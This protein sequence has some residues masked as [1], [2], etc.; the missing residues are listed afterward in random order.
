MRWHIVVRWDA[1]KSSENGMPR[2]P[3]MRHRITK[4]ARA[5]G[6]A[7]WVDAGKPQVRVPVRAEVTVRRGRVLDTKN[8][9]GALK[10]IIDGLFVGLL[11]QTRDPNGRKKF[12]TRLVP[13]ML[14]DDSAKW[15][16]WGET[17]QETGAKWKGC[18][19]IVFEIETAEEKTDG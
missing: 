19:E 10:P 3:L 2:H 13:S 8:I 1:E 14:P 7:A 5:A 6:F 17:K 4:A 15:L 16:S 9:D 18:E 12:R 11:F